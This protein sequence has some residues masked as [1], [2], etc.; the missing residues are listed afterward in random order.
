[1]TIN[2]SRARHEQ[3]LAL[4]E[5]HRNHVLELDWKIIIRNTCR[6]TMAPVLDTFPPQKFPYWAIYLMG[7][8]RT[9]TIAIE[10]YMQCAFSPFKPTLGTDLVPFAIIRIE[11]SYYG[12]WGCRGPTHKISFYSTQRT[13]LHPDWGFRTASCKAVLLRSMLNPQKGLVE[14]AQ[15]GVLANSVARLLFRPGV[16]GILA[17][18][19]LVG[20]HPFPAPSAPRTP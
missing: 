4:P 16:Q 17:A 10:L 11:P 8:G 15:G 9:E 5:Y 20:S 12:R 2:S 13:V 1:M 14:K 7:M 18:N 19:S 3:A 6:V